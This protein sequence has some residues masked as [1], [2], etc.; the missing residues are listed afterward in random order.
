MTARDARLR[1]L[2]NAN[3][4]ARS[5]YEAACRELLRRDRVGQPA[6]GNT[7]LASAA[8]T[9]AATKKAYDLANSRLRIARNTP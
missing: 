1:V 9:C 3:R 8:I 2:E 4:S 6:K 7:Q 5:A